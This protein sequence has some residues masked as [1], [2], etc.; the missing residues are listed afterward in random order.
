MIG[1]WGKYNLFYQ[2]NAQRYILHCQSIVLVMTI[3]DIQMWAI[4]C[5]L[6]LYRKHIFLNTR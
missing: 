3:F 5:S 4:C 1:H 6:V 2:Q